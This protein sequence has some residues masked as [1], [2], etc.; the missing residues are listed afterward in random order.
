L[1]ETPFETLEMAYKIGKDTG[2]KYVY[3]GNAPGLPS[4][5][6][7]CPKCDELCI[8]RAG[9]NVSRHDKNGK[10]QKCFTKLD[11]IN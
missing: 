1:Q 10:C 6:T 8:A 11:I 2:L 7:F 4:E 3:T 5:D 9:Y